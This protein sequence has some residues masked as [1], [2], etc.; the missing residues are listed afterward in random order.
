VTSRMALPVR[1]WR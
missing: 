1:T